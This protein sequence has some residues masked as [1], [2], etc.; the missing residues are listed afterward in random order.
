MFNFT[1]ALPL[2]T[3]GG[4]IYTTASFSGETQKQILAAKE[5]AAY[6]VATEGEVRT[7]RLQ[8]AV[9]SMRAENPALA[10]SDLDLA[11]AILTF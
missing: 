9:E 8:T 3:S 11:Q 5:D 1:L 4:V 7:A 10:A 2:T 6:F